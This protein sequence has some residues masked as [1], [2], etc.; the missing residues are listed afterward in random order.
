MTKDGLQGEEVQIG[1][2]AHTVNEIDLRVTKEMIETIRDD[3]T[4]T[5]VILREEI[6]ENTIGKTIEITVDVE[7]IGDTMTTGKES[8]AI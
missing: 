5:A 4:M 3:V 1:A 6:Q 7:M 2:K 8:Q